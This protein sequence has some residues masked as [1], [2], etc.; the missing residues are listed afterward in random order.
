[1]N[2]YHFSAEL[3]QKYGLD[4]AIM[5]HNLA[6]WVQKNTIDGRNIHDGRAWTYNSQESF[7]EWFPFWTRRQIQRVLKS[8]EDQ[9][10]IIKGNYNV[11]PM[12]RTLWYTVSDGIL[13]YYGIREPEEHDS[14]PSMDA[15]GAI[16][17]TK[18][19]DE[20]HETVPAI[21]KNKHKEKTKDTLTECACV[22][23]EQQF[24]LF[25]KKYPKKTAKIDAWER[26]K[27][28]NPDPELFAQIMA[29]LD[30]WLCSEQWGRGV[31]PHPATWLNKKRWKDENV[32]PSQPVSQ[33]RIEP[34]EGWEYV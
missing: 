33:Q 24:A 7:R 19:C 5:L 6:Y 1:M 27:R 11:R 2:E 22:D 28:L 13:E 16:D 3:A 18:P 30:M 15:N 20:T 29:G 25:W 4:E 34:G 12:D 23:Q 21:P 9:Q 31:I 8:L 14:V 17:G 26:W 10:A 32:I